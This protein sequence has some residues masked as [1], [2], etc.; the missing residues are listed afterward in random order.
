MPRSWRRDGIALALL[1]LLFYGA[2]L[3]PGVLWGDDAHLQ[4]QA[5]R[6]V[7][8]GSAGS[9]PLWV[10]IAHVF[11]LIPVG[12]V[13]GRVN[14]V[15]AM[16]GALTLPLVYWTARTLRVS[17]ASSIIA[18]L[19]LMV[20]HTFWSHAVRAEVYTLTLALM[21]LLVF[22]MARWTETGRAGWLWL[23]AGTLGLGLS[24]HLMVG[25]F[26]P[27]C[28]WLLW[29]GR[30]MLSVAAVGGAVLIGLIGVAPLLA[31]VTRDALA[32]HLR[33][34][35]VVRWALFSFEGYDFSGALFD[36]SWRL[37]PLDAFEWAVFLTLQFIGPALIAGVSGLVWSVRR[38]GTTWS[39]AV[40]LLYVGALSFSF[41]YR[42]GDR[43]VFYLPTYLP[44]TLWIALGVDGWRE[45]T[46]PRWE[47]QLFS[48]L[49]PLLVLYVP[50]LTYTNAPYLVARGI[51]FRDT[52]HVPGKMGAYFFLWPPKVWYNDGKN[53]ALDVLR[54]APPNAFILADPVL[55]APIAFVRDVEGLRSDVR[56][57]FCCWDIEAALR[58]AGARPVALVDLTPGIYPVA[59]V[60]ERYQLVSC[61]VLTCLAPLDKNQTSPVSSS[62]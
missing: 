61:G 5:V 3:A 27:A 55:Y 22:A 10:A 7:L 58:E 37:L 30:R 19:A 33:G 32:L 57:R 45:R 53:F 42:V 2:T 12:D 18:V 15:S 6:G 23:A 60:K 11:T 16:F 24:A 48:V 44:F 51:T 36:Y 4:L 46:H 47:R 29:R 1:G 59:W 34:W 14:A 8:Q 31:L 39:V 49:V 41:A 20:S 38:W 9:H 35:E 56:L 21:A 17:R 26:V 43:Y 28:L 50:W 54:S 52:R 40:A 62:P 13:A 25:L